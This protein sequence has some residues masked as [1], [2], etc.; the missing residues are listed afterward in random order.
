MSGHLYLSTACTH[1]QHRECRRRCKFC[2]AKCR[3]D[4]H[5]LSKLVTTVTKAAP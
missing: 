2:F 4:C 5:R 1:K 3:C